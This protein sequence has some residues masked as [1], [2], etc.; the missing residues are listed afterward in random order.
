MIGEKGINDIAQ[1][2]ANLENLTILEMSNL[3]I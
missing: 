3:I 2:I 1:P